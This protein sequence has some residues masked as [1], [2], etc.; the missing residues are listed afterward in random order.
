MPGAPE[1]AEARATAERAPGLASMLAARGLLPEEGLQRA[2]LI[3]RESGERLDA[4]VTR[5][6]M[7]S[8]D[9]LVTELASF[10]G[11][12]AIGAEA[13]PATPI[14]GPELSLAFLRDI[15]ALPVA[16][17]AD[18]VHIVVSN[19]FD[20]FVVQ[21]FA[22]MFQ[23]Q[24]ERVV[25][26]ASD[27]DAAIERL[28]HGQ[29]ASADAVEDA[30]DDEDLER[31]KDLVSDAPVIRAVN[32][33][34]ANA[35]DQRASDIH[36]EPG[37]DGL[38][39]RFRIDG[40]LR[41]AGRLPVAMRAPLVSRIKVMARL[42]IAERRLPQ[43]GRMR[44]SVR[45]HEIDLRVATAPSIHGE[46]VVMR[47]LD[48]SKLALDFA[49]L[50]FDA[51]LTGRLREAITRPHGIVLVTGPTG[52]GKTTTLY[53]ALSELNA[54]EHKLLTV[55]DPIEYR[56]DG[57]IQTQVNPAIGFTFGSALRSFLRQDPDVM[58]VGEIRDTETA[59]IAVQAA[60]TGH[61]I[62]STLHTNTAAGAVSRLL[63]MDVEPF[64][65]GSVLTGVLAQRL[66]RRLCPDCRTPYDPREDAP[67]ALRPLL[68]AEGIHRLYHPVGCVRCGGSG[69]SGR[70]ALLEFLR[71]DVAVSRLILRRADTREIL[72]A[73]EQGGMR[74][75]A[76]DGVAKAGEG[77]TTIEEVLRVASGDG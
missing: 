36:I 54:P 24:V 13:F 51:A 52:S 55:E 8:E 47:I 48:R 42:N 70:I 68:E 50:G 66:V 4:V 22:F 25:G 61:M 39:I 3:E 59:Q 30:V 15:R 67:E 14:E 7:L 6:G 20:P 77:L 65:L 63:D 64:L 41:D 62:L 43:D 38:A 35:V 75:L 72:A 60:L 56:L 32:R 57:V 18:V 19:P 17:D 31:L 40:M 21:A 69:Y 12:A 37:D 1:P 71:V 26:R 34:I 10:C 16:I 45:G 11:L 23:R 33:L 27:I 49:A 5:L 73:A 9:R 44:I 28:Y 29:R 58:M 74:S 46:S 76:A 53:A 2:L